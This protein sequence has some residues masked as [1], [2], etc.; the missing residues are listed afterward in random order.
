M[1]V[2]KAVNITKNTVV[3]EHVKI[4]DSYFPRFIGLMGKPGLPEGHGLWIVPC[5][6]IHSFF[7]RFEF[8][9]VFVDKEGKVLHVEKRMKPNRISKFVKGGR[10]VLE[11]D[12]GVIDQS[13]TEIGD[14]IELQEI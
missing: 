8:D 11:L 7:M 14:I 6:D 1:K 9:A 4:A 10:A 5:A 2:K 13:G 3:A 12:G